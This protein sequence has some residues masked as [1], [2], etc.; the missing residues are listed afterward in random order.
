VTLR[1]LPGI[2]PADNRSPE[3]SETRLPLPAADRVPRS[4]QTSCVDAGVLVVAAIRDVTERQHAITEQARLLRK[5]EAAKLK[6]RVL[7][8][9]APDAIVIARHDGRI[10]LV[11]H[12]HRGAMV[13][14][15]CLL[16]GCPP[17]ARHGRQ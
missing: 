7:L 10:A 5:T 6:F 9:A 15:R 4:P 3:R 2:T 12:R 1:R 14:P 16:R 17:T 8:E 13:N 11:N